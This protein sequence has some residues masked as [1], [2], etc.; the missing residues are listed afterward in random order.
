MSYLSVRWN[1]L[2]C[3]SLADGS[4]IRAWFVFAGHSRNGGLR[5]RRRRV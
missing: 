4:V 3:G 2:R 1:S 5:R